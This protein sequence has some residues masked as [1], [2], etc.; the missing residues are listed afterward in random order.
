MKKRIITYR[1]KIDALL[2]NPDDISPD[3]WPDVL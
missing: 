2:A 1:Q 3:C